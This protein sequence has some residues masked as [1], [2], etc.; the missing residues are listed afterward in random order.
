LI[1]FVAAAIF[2]LTPSDS[3]AAELNV[4]IN[5][6]PVNLGP[7]LDYL[8]DPDKS[9]RIEDIMSEIQNWQRSTHDIPTFG[10]SD[11]AF[12]LSIVSPAKN[13]QT[14]NCN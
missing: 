11:S 13:W 6:L 7:Y 10:L 3:S 9:L 12:W 4:G 14:L 5:Q 2:A 8:E 1:V